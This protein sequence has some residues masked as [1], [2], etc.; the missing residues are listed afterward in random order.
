MSDP[1]S[2]L[3]LGATGNTGSALV[4][5]LQQSPAARVRTATRAHQPHTPNEH[6]RFDWSDKTTFASA[7]DSIDRVYL[8][9]PV[10][11]ADPA[12]VVEPFLELAL[13]AGTRRVVLLSSSAVA[14]GEP[15]LGMV[16]ALV[17]EACPEWEVLRPSWFMQNF[18]GNHP[19]A[20]SIRNHAKFFTA[21]GSGRL[22]F[23]DAEDI[24]RAAAHLLMV[25][26]SNNSEHVLTGP[27]ALSY[28]EAAAVLSNATG[29]KVD[30]VAVTSAEYTDRLVQAGYEPEFAAALAALDERIR[31]GEQEQVTG[32]VAR[33]TGR[34]PRTFVDYVDLHLESSTRATT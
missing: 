28:D 17:R 15:G 23:I 7:V 20:D 11:E 21:T 8:V 27:Q 16:D 29:S 19:L 31:N 32:T 30:H 2:I 24:G 9:A 6:V 34:E 22:P 12:R 1:V 33:L 18:T 25:P 14:P 26:S 3:V 13:A 5:S 10:G 4:S